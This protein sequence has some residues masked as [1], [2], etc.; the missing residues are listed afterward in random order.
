MD[1]MEEAGK[2]EIKL[3]ADLERKLT[4]F[5]CNLSLCCEFGAF[6]YFICEIYLGW[7]LCLFSQDQRT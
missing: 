7:L 6:Y 4:P 5:Q 3:K 2:G 1:L